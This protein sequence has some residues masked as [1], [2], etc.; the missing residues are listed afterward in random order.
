MMAAHKILMTPSHE[1]IAFQASSCFRIG[2]LAKTSVTVSSFAACQKY[3]GAKD[4]AGS[5]CTIGRPVFT[6]GLILAPF[7]LASD[8][9]RQRLQSVLASLRCSVG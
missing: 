9:L 8:W 6:P 7:W 3:E 5:R 4:F 1:T 2:I